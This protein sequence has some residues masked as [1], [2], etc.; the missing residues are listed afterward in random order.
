M[1]VLLI[2]LPL[3]SSLFFW[4]ASLLG[5]KSLFTFA[6]VGLLSTS[7]VALPLLAQKRIDYFSPLMM[8]YYA[9]AIGGGARGILVAT[10]GS[11]TF[12]SYTAGFDW[13][14]IVS[15]SIW[16]VVGLLC[17][18]IG[19]LCSRYT[20]MSAI[21]IQFT[22]Y[23]LS[24][25]RVFVV[26]FLVNLASFFAAS[27]YTKV[28]GVEFTDIYS[29]SNKRAVLL[30]NSNTYVSYGYLKL[31]GSL[32]GYLFI[33]L[34]SL[35]IFGLW[36]TRRWMLWCALVP[37]FLLAVYV[38]F[39]SS[40]RIEIILLL[41]NG[42][43]IFYYKNNRVIPI[44]PALSVCAVVVLISSGMGYLRYEAQGKQSETQINP[45]ETIVG[46]GNF[47]DVAR[48][49]I[50][51]EHVPDRMNFLYGS[52]LIS[53][54]FSPI[55]RAFWPQKP[56]ISLGPVVKSK[57]WGVNVRKNGFPPGVV[58]EGYL[59]FGYPGIVIVPFLFG[60][61]LG[62]FYYSIAKRLGNSLPVTVLYSCVIWR[63][64][65]GAVGLNVSLGLLQVATSAILAML[66]LRLVMT[67]ERRR[68]S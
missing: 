40:S 61:V 59:N 33:V 56:D 25:F 53:W 9:T 24:H 13:A 21:R 29:V 57:V 48:T 54:V 36:S 38:P 65:F 60:W 55:P 34:L 18:G 44:G 58:A 52:S 14:D 28:M 49:S 17:I 51:I 64:S 26:F 11:A 39:V 46:S 20:K 19:Y 50:I 62:S 23:K 31:A 15:N 27:A 16:S 2:A 42:V 8:I 68:E 45:I 67:R 30:E 10:S 6:A 35:A 43:I 5:G 3:V 4:G 47:V 37:T 66:I 7:V 63:A 32:S 1:R 22:E 41:L 12:D